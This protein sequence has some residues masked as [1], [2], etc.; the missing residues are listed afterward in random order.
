MS[1][2]KLTGCCG[3]MTKPQCSPRRMVE[4]SETH[5]WIADGGMTGFGYHLY[6][7]TKEVTILTNKVSIK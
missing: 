2:D 3:V 7:F 4:H 1:Q 5:Q 6:P